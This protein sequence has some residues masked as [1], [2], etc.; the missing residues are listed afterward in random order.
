[1]D[2]VKGFFKKQKLPEHK[3]TGLVEK[4]KRWTMSA[5]VTLFQ[6]DNYSFFEH[7][8]I[9]KTKKEARGFIIIVRGV[10]IR[11]IVWLYIMLLTYLAFFGK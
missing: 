1:L 11:I 10:R 5:W 3:L 4:C 8:I 7:L 2:T 9:N 6:H